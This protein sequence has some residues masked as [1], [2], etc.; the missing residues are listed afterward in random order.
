MGARTVTS[1]LSLQPL[2]QVLQRLRVPLE[3]QE[4]KRKMVFFSAAKWPPPPGGRARAKQV[5]RSSFCPRF[6]VHAPTYI[7]FDGRFQQNL[8]SKYFCFHTN[9]SKTALKGHY[10]FGHKSYSLCHGQTV[11]GGV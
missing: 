11:G 4:K 9:M 3:K 6:F 5:K 2:R 7:L 10:Q 1:L 8:S